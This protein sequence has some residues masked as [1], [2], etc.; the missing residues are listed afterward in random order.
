MSA[1]DCRRTPS[2]STSFA[3][4]RLSAFQLTRR[5]SAATATQRKKSESGQTLAAHAPNSTGSAVKIAVGGSRTISSISVTARKKENVGF[6]RLRSCG[7]G[8]DD[9]DFTGGRCVNGRDGS[10]VEMGMGKEGCAKVSV[11]PVARE[12]SPTK[13][14]L[15]SAVRIGNK[16]VE[17]SARPDGSALARQRR[18]GLSIRDGQAKGGDVDGVHRRLDAGENEGLKKVGD[19]K[20]NAAAGRALLRKSSTRKSSC[21]SVASNDTM[22][23]KNA[24]KHCDCDSEQ[25]SRKSGND[26]SLVKPS[27]ISSTSSRASCTGRRESARQQPITP[28]APSQSRRLSSRRQSSLRTSLGCVEPSGAC[29]RNVSSAS[30]GSANDFCMLHKPNDKSSARWKSK[31]DDLRCD[32]AQTMRSRTIPVKSLQKS[33]RSTLAALDAEKLLMPDVGKRDD[34]KNNSLQSSLETVRRQAETLQLHLLHSVMITDVAKKSTETNRSLR[35]NLSSIQDAYTAMRSKEEA[36]QSL[37]NRIAMHSWSYSADDNNGSQ[38]DNIALLITILDEFPALLGSDD[39]KASISCAGESDEVSDSEYLY[40]HL[41]EEFES[42][43]RQAQQVWQA[44]EKHGI[45]SL[46][47]STTS[48]VAEYRTYDEST[49]AHSY[50]HFDKSPYI[51]KPMSTSWYTKLAA[52]SHKLDILSQSL[53]E[54]EPAPEGST[55]ASI[56]QRCMA[57]LANA[58]QELREMKETEETVFSLEIMNLDLK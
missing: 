25:L 12:R 21:G 38:A 11:V 48:S 35:A 8:E 3:H 27:R 40:A 45:G 15:P 28:I 42:W 10:G 5:S 37:I 29:S 46:L 2:R 56:L 39:E 26:F 34:D 20:I 13:L 24:G 19:A 32:E 23:T 33:R 7:N 57:F 17:F 6:A 41:I 55:L 14:P 53:E 44:R 22:K 30:A 4:G 18:V 54:L 50:S 51:I 49:N 58:T 1:T 52:L 43:M 47:S 31:D 16:K 9:V 36:A